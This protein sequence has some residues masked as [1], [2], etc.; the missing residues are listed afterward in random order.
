[1]KLR[2]IHIFFVLLAILILSN[3]GIGV[4]E[5]FENKDD[6]QQGISKKDIPDG[7][8]NLYILKS[9]IVPPVCPKCPDVQ[10]CA[11]KL[12]VLH[13]LLVVVVLNLHLNVKKCQ[14][15]TPK[16]TT[17]YQDQY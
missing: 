1:M 16:M 12:N 10:S 13:V 15:T 6:T 8:E 17:T 4:R 2:A 9:E 11:K 7:D 5:Y 14:I 3:L